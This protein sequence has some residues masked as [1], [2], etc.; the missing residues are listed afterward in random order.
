MS[1]EIGDADRPSSPRQIFQA[2]IDRPGDVADLRRGD[3]LSGRGG[4]AQP[5]VLSQQRL[6]NQLTA[7]REGIGLAALPCFLGDGEAGL[8]RV[9]G[10]IPELA[11]ELWPVTHEDLR[12]TARIEAFFAM[13]AA[14][15]KED[16]PLL[17][18]RLVA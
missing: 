8:A 9:V 3:A 2:A 10:P 7:V 13:M 6:L 16:R 11:R 18:G 17:E 14:A 5:P 15:I 4:A 1:G 12:R